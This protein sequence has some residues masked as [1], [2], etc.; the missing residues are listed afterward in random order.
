MPS[1]STCAQRKVKCNR[2]NPCSNC[3]KHKVECVYIS[4]SVRKR[5]SEANEVEALQEQIEEYRRKLKSLENKP[6]TKSKETIEFHRDESV[7]EDVEN[8]SESSAGAGNL[9][10]SGTPETDSLGQSKLTYDQHAANQLHHIN[11][12]NGTAL[13]IGMNESDFLLMP[14][15]RKANFSDLHPSPVQVFQLWQL[16]LDNVNPLTKVLHTPTVQCLVV[17]ACSSPEKVSLGTNALLFAIYAV[18]VESADDEFCS[19]VFEQSKR[20]ML[21][22]YA[23]SAKM[24][25]LRANFLV[26]TDMDILQAYILYLL[27]VRQYYNRR[28]YWILTGVAARLAEHVNIRKDL[29]SNNN[30]SAIYENEMRRRIWWQIRVLDGRSSQ[31]TGFAVAMPDSM[32]IK[33]MPS[34]LNDSEIYL[35]MTELPKEHKGV[36]EMVFCLTRYKIGHFLKSS[37]DNNKSIT[38][39]DRLTDPSVSIEEKQALLDRLQKTIENE[40][41]RYCDQSIPLHAL[42]AKLGTCMVLK[43]RLLLHHPRH[44]AQGWAS[45]P[46]DQ[47]G[48]LLEMALKIIKIYI[49]GRHRESMKR[50]TWHLISHFQLD[51]FVLLISELQSSVSDA[52]FE[53]SWKAVEEVYSIHP[54]L[55]EDSSTLYRAI[56]DLTLR[57]WEKREVELVVKTQ[58]LPLEPGFISKFRAQRGLSAP[59]EA[60]IKARNLSLQSNSENNTEPLSKSDP[61]G[62]TMNDSIDWDFWI[63]QLES[64]EFQY[65]EYTEFL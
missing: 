16:F 25:L 52:F 12:S 65:S 46:S 31:L 23:N 42:A 44:Y 64:H 11:D 13:N 37:S 50:F 6:M 60:S 19:R 58:Q 3:L 27:A 45:I 59:S 63:N 43:M 28:A 2:E 39:L 61:L 32:C 10:N 1:C 33:N 4:K 47:R 38:N 5:K 53:S 17:E 21:T 20:A 49:E 24:A 41:L 62:Q 29:S 34:N 30:G 18:A 56:G 40:F 8:T 55:T 48:E 14:V 7:N 26:S 15:S 36:T 9:R 35:E 57:V 54:E 51:V 22:K